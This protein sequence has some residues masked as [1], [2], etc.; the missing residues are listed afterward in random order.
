MLSANPIV[1]RRTTLPPSPAE[2]DATVHSEDEGFM[3]KPRMIEL[4][5]L[6]YEDKG[7]RARKA[8]V[9]Q[10][11]ETQVNV[12]VLEPGGRVPSHHHTISWDISCV[13]DGENDA[14]CTEDGATRTVR[15]RRGSVTLVRPGAV[16]EISNPSETESARFPL[17]QSPA[18]GFDFVRNL[19]AASATD[20]AGAGQH[21][22]SEA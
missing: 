11:A 10:S 12:Y 5:T 19:P 6:D 9:H 16:H 8:L 22:Q 15:C 7:L 4:A 20:I 2:S 18:H 14:T 17:V 21:A 13:L 1:A 3:P